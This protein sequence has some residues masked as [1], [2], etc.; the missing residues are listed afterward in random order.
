[1]PGPNSAPN[2]DADLV[3]GYTD[4]LVGCEYC[5]VWDDPDNKPRAKI[6]LQMPKRQHEARHGRLR[7][8]KTDK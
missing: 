2:G 3:T 6:Y 1:M 4:L 5:W 8:G 7:T